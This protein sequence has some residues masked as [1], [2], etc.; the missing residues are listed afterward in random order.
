V[1]DNGLLVSGIAKAHGG[2]RAG[3]SIQM[4]AQLEKLLAAANKDLPTF[5]GNLQGARDFMQTYA[6]MGEQAPSATTSSGG[7]N[8][9]TSAELAAIAKKNGTTIEQERKRATDAGYVIR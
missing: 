4:I 6:D 8:A 9:V 7:G 3:G 1:T 2:A 5:L